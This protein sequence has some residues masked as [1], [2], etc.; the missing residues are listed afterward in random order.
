[1]CC[2]YNFIIL[3]DHVH[4]W[5]VAPGQYALEEEPADYILYQFTIFSIGDV[6]KKKRNLDLRVTRD[7]TVCIIGTQRAVAFARE[8]RG[9]E[10]RDMRN[11]VQG[12][13]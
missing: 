10:C 13:V 12:S 3:R 1:M 11:K 6:E 4:Y 8:N 7:R 9:R 5:I 2:E